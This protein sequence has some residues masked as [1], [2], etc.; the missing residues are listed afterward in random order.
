MDIDVHMFKNRQK[1]A[2]FTVDCSLQLE[3]DD[4]NKNSKTHICMSDSQMYV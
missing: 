4:K 3:E 1:I 2:Q